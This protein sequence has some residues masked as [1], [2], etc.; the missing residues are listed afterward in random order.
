MNIFEFLYAD[1]SSPP[2]SGS[3]SEDAGP[4]DGPV[5]DGADQGVTTGPAD[6]DIDELMKDFGLS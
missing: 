6:V 4:G 2:F 1:P 3:T 5:T